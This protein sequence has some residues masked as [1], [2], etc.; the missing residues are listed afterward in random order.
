MIVAPEILNDNILTTTIC[1]V[2]GGAAGITLAC[3]LDGAPFKVLLLEAGDFD[4]QKSHY[5]GSASAPHADPSEFRRFGFGGT[6]AAWGGRCVPY[7]PIDFVHRDHVPNSGWPISYH[8]VA[9]YYPRAMKYCDAGQFD[10]SVEGSLRRSSE[11]IPGLDGE[12][13]TSDRIERYSLPTHFGRRYRR[14]IARSRNVTAVLKTR[15]VALDKSKGEDRIQ[16]LQ[17]V[18]C[19][20]RRHLVYADVFVLA[21]GGIETPRLLFA[22][23]P[24]GAGLGNRNDNLGRFY[25]CHF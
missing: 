7:D 17:V 1:I 25:A 5:E 13:I 18:D 24:A 20:N 21:V 6:T 23:D 8:E 2:G 4:P 14:R 9:R 11:T 19:A 12:I 15:C 16:S 10:F 22:A 3:E